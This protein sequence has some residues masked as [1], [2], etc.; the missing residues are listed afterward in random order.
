MF[1]F[2]TVF[3]V[4]FLFAANI[5]A[6]PG[7]LNFQA[8][9]KTSTGAA[10]ESNNV[11]FV[12]TY[13]NSTNSCTLYK[14][15]YSAYDMT[16]S[17]G[18]VNFQF[19]ASLANRIY[20]A[21]GGTALK[22]IFSNE[23]LTLT[24]L[25]GGT[26]PNPGS[27]DLRYL[28]I[29]F[30]YAGSGGWNTL[31][32]I[33]LNSVP[34]AM[35]ATEASKLSGLVSSDF[36]LKADVP[37]CTAPNV[38]TK[39][40][41]VWS[42]AAGGGGT[43]TST[44][45]TTAL[46]YTPQASS[47]RLTEIA[48]LS[49]LVN[50]IIKWNGTNWVASNFNSA[51]VTTALGF[52]PS[53][54]AS[55]V[56]SVAGRTGVVT[57]SSSDIT[58]FGNS[59][60]LNVGT[61]AGTVAA[62]DDGR[63]ADQRI[64]TD[65]SVTSAKISSGA[66]TFDKINQS[67]ATTGQVIKWDGGAWVA[68]N[69]I[70]NSG[71]VTSV[72]A[73]ASI[74]NPII[75]GGS[76]SNPTI[77]LA[78][79]NAA[80]SGYLSSSDFTIFNNKLAN[81][82]TMTSVDIS[83]ALT[84][85]PVNP[86]TLNNYLL[87][88]GG[89]LSGNLNLGGN[90]I[91]GLKNAANTSADPTVTEDGKT[92]RWNNAIQQWEWFTAG[93]AG[94][95]PANL[96]TF[97]LV[98]AATTLP[99][100]L[101]GN[102]V[103]DGV[104]L[105]D[106][107]RVLV[108]N[109]TIFNSAQH[110]VYVVSSGAWTRATDFDTWSETI[111]YVAKVTEGIANSGMSYTTSTASGGVLDS[112][113]VFFVSQ[114]MSDT[115]FNMGFGYQALNKN[116]TGDQN[117]AIGKLSMQENTTGFYNTAVG[118]ES[119]Q[120]NT[121]GYVNTAVGRG[122]LL[123]ST[124]GSFNTAIGRYAFAGLVTGDHN[125]GLGYGAGNLITSGSNNV[126][127][128]S[129]YGASIDGLSNYI[130]IADGAGN[131]R[132][133]VDNLGR[134]GIGTTAPAYA[135]EVSGD[136][137]ISGK[138][139]INGIDIASGAGTVT[140]V[141]ASAPLSATVG[142]TPNITLAKA[143][144]STD[145]YLSSAD[146]T[147]FNN[148]QNNLGYTPLNPAASGLSDGFIKSATGI[149][150]SQSSI[151][152]STDVTGILPIANGGTNATTANGALNNLLPTQSSSKVLQ[153]DG[154]N[155]SWL[156]F[157]TAASNNTLVQRDGSGISNFY[158][159]GITG[160]STGIVT[161]QSPNI[162]T[163]YSLTLPN[164]QGANNQVLANNG[165]GVLSWVTAL[166][167]FSSITSND[168]SS[169]N[170]FVQNGN[171]FG[172]AANI[173]TND[174]QDLNLKTNNT[175]KMTVAANGN[176]GIGTSSPAQ[177][178]DI[179]DTGT[180]VQRTRANGLVN[181]SRSYIQVLRDNA[182]ASDGWDI[183]N[184][185]S[186]ANDEFRIREI[187]SG[188][189]GAPTRLSILK[190]GNV[191][192]GTL[193]PTNLLSIDSVGTDYTKHYIKNRVSSTNTTWQAVAGLSLI[194][195]HSDDPLVSSPTIATEQLGEFAIAGTNLDGSN[196][197]S[198][199][200]KATQVGTASSGIPVGSNLT[201]LTAS[202]MSGGMVE[203]VIVDNLGNVGVGTS[204]PLYKLDVAGE[205]RFGSIKMGAISSDNTSYGTNVYDY[206]TFT[207][208]NNQAQNIT[209]PSYGIASFIED[210]SATTA[211]TGNAGLKFF[212]F[213]QE[214]L[215]ILSNGA[216]G[217]GT[218]AP[219]A[220][221]MLDLTSTT[222]GFLLPRMTTVQRDA[223]SSPVTGLQIYNTTN[224]TNDYFNGTSWTT[225]SGVSGGGA[226]TG[227]SG[228]VNISAGG[229]NQNIT[230]AASGTGV[231]TTA[232][233][234]TITNSTVSTTPSTGA[235]VVNGGVGIGGALNISGRINGTTSGTGWFGFKD[236][237]VLT[238]YGTFKKPDDTALGY[239]GG[240]AGAATTSGT[241][242]DLS[243]R[244]EQDLI[245]ASGGNNE[246][247]RI[248]ANGNVGIGTTAPISSLHVVDTNTGQITIDAYGARAG[249]IARSASGTLSS[250]GF[251]T[252]GSNMWAMGGRPYN[253]SGFASVATA[254]I[255]GVAT[256]NHSSTNLG[257][258][259]SFLTT[260]NGA[261]SA[262]E[263]MR[264]DSSGN[265]GV[266]TSSPNAKLDVSGAV[267]TSTQLYVGNSN[268]TNATGLY[269]TRWGSSTSPMGIQGTIAGVGQG[270]IVLQPQAGNVG[271]GT[272][273]PVSKLDILADYNNV[274]LNANDPASLNLRTPGHVQFAINTQL[275]SPFTTSLQAKHSTADGGSYPIALNPLGG[276]V[277]VGTTTPSAKLSIAGATEN[278]N[279]GLIRHYRNV[280][281]YT[282]NAVSVT[283]TIKIT[284]PSAKLNSTTM[285]N[286]TI[287]GYD[288]S[289]SGGA[290]EVNVSGYNYT[291]G[292]WYNP[293][294]QIR[295]NAPF[296]TVR[297]A[298][299][300]TSKV[301]LLGTTSTNWAYPQI[302]V[303]DF[304]AAFNN[305]TDWAAGWSA[306]RITSEAGIAGFA[307]MTTS[308]VATTANNQPISVNTSQPQ[309][310]S[311][312][313]AGTGYADAT[314]GVATFYSENTVGSGGNII[315]AGSAFAPNAFVVKDSGNV[316][317][318]VASPAAKLDVGGAIIGTKI[319]VNGTSNSYQLS[320]VGNSGVVTSLL[321]VGINDVSNG[322]TIN[323]DA[324][325]NLTYSMLTGAGSQGFYQ[326]SA[327]S[328]GIGTTSPNAN[329][330]IYNSSTSS[331]KITSAADEANLTLAGD[332]GFGATIN[333]QTA[334]ANKGIIFS[335]ETRMILGTRTA[336][337]LKFNTN[338]GTRMTINA[339]GS[340]G[341]GTTSPTYQLQLSTDSAAK[342]GTSTWTIA[343]DERLKDIRAPFT[344]G[345]NELM[346]LNTIYFNYKKNNPLNLPS[347]KEFVGIKAQ[348]AQ[349]VIPESVTTD[350][351][352][353]L[354][355]T[356]DSIIWTAVN[357]IK[358]L[359]RK[360]LGHD[361]ILANQA[362]QIASKDQQIKDLKKENDEIRNRLDKIEKALNT[363]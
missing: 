205:A 143:D 281:E 123:S 12:F 173:G 180:V 39:I 125:V 111:G 340:V 252:A 235:L 325:D 181:A 120:S 347:E 282:E 331:Q 198:A 38:L 134:V 22:D 137:S 317:I 97:Y 362:R 247:I 192:I 82:S 191:G 128:G 320:S 2:R 78:K 244:A 55:S 360:V 283:G 108:K 24:C 330:E 297:L 255:S 260:Q 5:F 290:W 14:E 341:I 164:A 234:V 102:Q 42:C 183:S 151:A 53:N 104:A 348:D 153:T 241:S 333:L 208:V 319:S 329:L 149:L 46:T 355:V 175:T 35:F 163:S 218:T 91:L 146:F 337:P 29:Q 231:V 225:S 300:G 172:A 59:A 197:H 121:T 326:N 64:P 285:M 166:T 288:Y 304:I 66:I 190:G 118:N 170:G 179:Q 296:T 132:L 327:G 99:V 144:A 44:D 195:N 328:V 204:T 160:A 94:G 156:S 47:A 301:I 199:S 201:I 150:S 65:N 200:I 212:T 286:I 238:N 116:T 311:V 233:P 11:D 223:I 17:G 158:G 250:P 217:I 136:V 140:S 154:T 142:A 334:G 127:I 162:T 23:N 50:Q 258:G 155:S 41:G 351:K 275:A 312:I 76:G 310:F 196:L 84:Y 93:A 7:T 174:N 45:V 33:T 270:P 148:K 227:S 222:K 6:A 209:L 48:G 357:A 32:P 248:A 313:G 358:E 336:I 95:L 269:F 295:G 305:T 184:N 83:M 52:T 224:N 117:V 346:G 316:G 185:S 51:D 187:D 129:N 28:I 318:G 261:L 254:Y 257:S 96:Q 67:A 259:L 189:G 79:S 13:R 171:S 86:S 272:N 294:S 271:I 57:L 302:V 268:T 169:A 228:A 126:V 152:L 267:D 226:I 69:D 159:V 56:T 138:F 49:P 256:E 133:R 31:S 124:T 246:R 194:K 37:N 262:T 85:T 273:T 74:N 40:A 229:T 10:L 19:G 265:V 98:R 264:I 71:T 232:S 321:L 27:A 349:K 21:S 237:G 15:S 130:L 112:S 251:W 61:T 363:K 203:R 245:F 1:N 30:Q 70:S 243:L 113:Y 60:G 131:E 141:T 139:K 299:D 43:I 344:R 207:H 68:S 36:T 263:K 3:T 186:L 323:S 215:R 115:S 339:T 354:H 274:S 206:T 216:I 168:I 157:N 214:R 308:Q 309:A 277:G 63:F 4:L 213:G 324:S 240:G 359:Y 178:L 90:K 145:G 322:F 92:L 119:L 356:N 315:K 54:A 182:G 100:T 293:S 88:T 287:R 230:L 73:A 106:G 276:N 289:A 220:T 107:D 242:S 176:V 249:L 239:L 202:G 253:G 343:S 303:S 188:S 80:T 58:G 72:T 307:S 342:P 26:I 266:G 352:G 292:A 114:G 167:N 9:I 16:G 87:L 165:S 361:E 298:N 211:I 62:G 278:S 110:G 279:A 81:F 280:V 25:E 353:F 34:F 236:T 75:V 105:V 135:L 103:V 161:F 77:D 122:A 350:E 219:A 109:Q 89:T 221:A 147:T 193:T 210:T 291:D 314:N 335:D 345:L 101:S 284:L 8:R 332:T 18:L 306:S 338:D 177:K 20:P